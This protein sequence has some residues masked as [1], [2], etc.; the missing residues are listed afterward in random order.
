MLLYAQPFV[1]QK[2]MENAP[3]F[4]LRDYVVT[5][6]TSYRE[7][8]VQDSSWWFSSQKLFALL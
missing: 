7:T 2:Q 5:F 1:N 3:F 8:Q 6:C 4:L